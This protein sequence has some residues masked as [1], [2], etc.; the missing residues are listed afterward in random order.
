MNKKLMPFILI[1][2]LLLFKG[3]SGPTGP[4]GPSGPTGPT[5]PK[6]DP[7]DA[8]IGVTFDLEGVNFTAANQYTF[9][10]TFDDADVN[11]L[12]SDAVLVYIHWN[13][14]KVGNETL[15]AWR[16]LPQT[17]IVDQGILMYNFDRTL[18][19]FSVFLE[20]NFNLANL[21][22]DWTQN[23]TFRVIVIPSDF[24]TRKSG[25]IDYTDYNAVKKLMNIDESKIRK[26][27]V[28]K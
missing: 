11:V 27:K 18:K 17:A 6:G 13:D 15:A 3:C 2:T 1:F 14:Q 20:G 5:G 8:N 12:E 16:L 7:G 26:I 24:A 23:Q 22:S 4:E 21:A 9:G 10:L 19:D 25:G 28:K